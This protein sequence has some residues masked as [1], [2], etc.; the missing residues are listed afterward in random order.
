MASMIVM[1]TGNAFKI[2]SWVL[3]SATMF[4]TFPH[5]NNSLIFCLIFP[6]LFLILFS[7]LIF[8]NYLILYFFDTKDK[9]I[10]PIKD[11]DKT[12]TTKKEPRHDFSM[13]FVYS[14][15]QHPTTSFI[16]SHFRCHCSPLGPSDPTTMRLLSYTLMFSPMVTC[17]LIKTPQRNRI[18]HQFSS[19][20]EM[21]KYSIKY[22][23]TNPRTH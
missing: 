16:W 20:T 15:P 17:Q 23:Q 3:H 21:Q 13:D 11:C 22:R 1:Q 19:W 10:K 12:T 7:M 9:I 14:L 18:S 5:R 6:F 2:H 4:Y 8:L